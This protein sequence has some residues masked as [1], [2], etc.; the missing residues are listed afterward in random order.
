[1]AHERQTIG[2]ALEILSF[3]Y[4]MRSRSILVCFFAC[5]SGTA[6]EPEI[7][8]FIAAGDGLVVH[9]CGACSPAGDDII[10]EGDEFILLM[11]V[12]HE[13]DAFLHVADD[14]ARALGLEADDEI[15]DDV[16]LA[17]AQE[18]SEAEVV[19]AEVCADAGKEAALEGEQGLGGLFD[20]GF[21]DEF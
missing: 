18:L 14:D 8:E 15:G 6:K 1:M 4:E 19:D 13:D 17:F 11:L 7:P 10:C 20:F 21:V 12:H 16:G 9:H 2:C 5:F 3:V